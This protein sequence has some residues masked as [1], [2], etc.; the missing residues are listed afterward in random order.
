[1]T[2]EELKDLVSKSNQSPIRI[3]LSD[4]ANYKLS[5]PDYGLVT[6]DSLILADGPGHPLR[7]EFVICSINEITRVEIL[8][9]RRR[10]TKAS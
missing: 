8:R 4:G 7:A 6:S 9:S 1:M 3:H 5:H 10:A 2:R